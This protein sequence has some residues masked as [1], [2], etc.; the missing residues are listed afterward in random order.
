MLEQRLARIADRCLAHVLD[1]DA[2]A[3]KCHKRLGDFLLTKY[4]HECGAIAALAEEV[5]VAA[6][7]GVPLV[8][9]LLLEDGEDG[10][11]VYPLPQGGQGTVVGGMPAE[12]II[13]EHLGHVRP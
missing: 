3:R 7:R 9:D 5:R 12:H 13:D 10:E 8:N 2:V 11:V 1:I 6:E 4:T